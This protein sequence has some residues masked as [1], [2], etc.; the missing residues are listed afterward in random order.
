MVTIGTCGLLL[1][2]NAWAEP[3]CDLGDGS[4]LD[5]GNNLRWV[6]GPGTGTAS[7]GNATT[8]AASALGGTGRLPTRAEYQLLQ[9]QLAGNSTIVG[10]YVSGQNWTSEVESGNFF[11]VVDLSDNLIGRRNRNNSVAFWPVV[12]DGT[13]VCPATAGCIG[14][15]YPTRLTGASIPT[16]TD[17]I[18]GNSIDADSPGGGENWKEIHCGTSPG[19]LQKIGVSPTDPVDPQ[20][21]VGSWGIVGAVGEETVNY[22]YGTGGSYTW[23]VYQNGTG[24]LCWQEDSDTGAVIATGAV[25]A[26]SCI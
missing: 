5:D 9:P 19:E 3:L 4:F 22:D 14:F 11:Y 2:G 13:S 7:H 26:V 1:G 12:S 17:A 20:V 21:P 24:G 18:T 25:T 10:A 6:Q 15:G 23:R 8:D 16:L